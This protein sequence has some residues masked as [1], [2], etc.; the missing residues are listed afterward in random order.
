M[1]LDEIISL[2][3]QG[4]LR[5]RFEVTSISSPIVI[6]HSNNV[7]FT[8]K[9]G[10]EKELVG[11]DIDGN[12]ILRV[13]YPETRSYAG[14]SPGISFGAIIIPGYQTKLVSSIH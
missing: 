9:W 10:T 3:Y 6:D 4:Q 12:E 5:W 7:F 11:I 2:D 8:D 14:Y 1:G 13:S